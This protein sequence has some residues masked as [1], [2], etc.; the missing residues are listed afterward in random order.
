MK[1]VHVF[2]KNAQEGQNPL[3]Y[4]DVMLGVGEEGLIT[5]RGWKLMETK[6][7]TWLATPSQ[8]G[9]NDQWYPTIVF[10]KESQQEGEEKRALTEQ[11]ERFKNHIFESVKAAYQKELEKNG[12]APAPAK[13]QP[14]TRGDF[15][16]DPD[17]FG[18]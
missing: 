10:Q 9:A 2:I 15:G 3:C 7:E 8:K 1:V 18:W 14:E 13:H 11:A 17:G 4:A 5:L 6:G 12:G 16:N